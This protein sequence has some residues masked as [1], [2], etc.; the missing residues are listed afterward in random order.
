[1]PLRTCKGSERTSLVGITQ[2]VHPSC[3]RPC[4]QMH[5]HLPRPLPPLPVNAAKRR[6]M[7]C[8]SPGLSSQV[9]SSSSEEE[10][11][12]GEPDL[13]WLADLTG[14]HI[15]LAPICEDPEDRCSI[16]ENLVSLVDFQ[17]PGFP[18]TSEELCQYIDIPH[19]PTSSSTTTSTVTTR[20][21]VPQPPLPTG[22][23]DYKSNAHVRPPYSYATLICMAMEASKKPKITLAAICKWISDNFCYFRRADPSW[24]SSIRHNLCINKRFIKVPREKGEPGRGAFWK[25]HPRYAEQ[26]QSS[27]SKELPEPASTKRAQQEAQRVLSPATLACSSQSSLEVGAELQQLLQEFEEFESSHS[28]NPVENEAGQQQ[29]HNQPWP[30]PLAEVS[31]L[32]SSASGPQEEPSEL[33]ELKGSTDW[34]ALLDFAPEQGD[35]S[36]LEHL[37]LPLPTPPGVVHPT[38]QGQQQV[39]PEGS[40]TKLG[41][42]ENLMA[43]AFLEAVWHEEMR[44][45]PSDG[46]PTVQGAENIQASL[47]EGDAIDWESLA[48]IGVY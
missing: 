45:S 20:Q 29:Q 28:W 5:R 46:I 18:L 16:W 33:M 38:A 31:W 41:L 40:P 25:L 13:L 34:E 36:A 27:T 2:G 43:T 9:Q 32:P 47:P 24:Q 12:G 48:H 22:D 39:L 7:V 8:P 26:L 30:T 17:C 4:S 37:E 1:M 10:Q 42:D 15:G 35:F 21:A 3:R 14:A 11:H 23:I 6:G 19:T 44:D